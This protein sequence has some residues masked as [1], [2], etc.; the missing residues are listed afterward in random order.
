MIPLNLSEHRATDSAQRQLCAL[1]GGY[2][3]QDLCCM[4]EFYSLLG[5]NFKS[6]ENYLFLLQLISLFFYTI[7]AEVC[8]CIWKWMRASGIW[9]DWFIFADCVNF[10]KGPGS[11]LCAALMSC[12]ND[13]WVRLAEP[14]NQFYFP[15]SLALQGDFTACF[16][17]SKRTHASM[18]NSE[19]RPWLAP[20]YLPWV[21]FE[22]KLQW[23]TML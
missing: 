19:G 20:S 10:L 13:F 5:T 3:I 23:C 2:K 17:C 6:R 4:P 15:L 8:S 7:L 16:T 22:T 11:L 12:R 18:G 1:K 21:K 14:A 9:L